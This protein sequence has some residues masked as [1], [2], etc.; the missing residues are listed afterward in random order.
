MR[1]VFML[2]S[3]LSLSGSVNAQSC[4]E[5]LISCLQ[6][7]SDLKDQLLGNKD[8]WACSSLCNGSANVGSGNSRAEAIR[9]AQ[10]KA[11]YECFGRERVDCEIIR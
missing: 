9:N 3:V 4:S 11:K 10:L 2:L 1:F 6:E 8:K 7:N 5:S